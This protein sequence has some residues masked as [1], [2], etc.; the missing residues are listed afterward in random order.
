MVGFTYHLIKSYALGCRILW[1]LTSIFY[2][3]YLSKMMDTST[4]YSYFEELLQCE[5]E[6]V[7]ALKVLMDINWNQEGIIDFIDYY[8]FDVDYL[9]S[10]IAEWV[11]NHR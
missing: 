4:I 5:P 10:D 1:G 7:E 8:G 9:N 3:L 6:K 2:T 11:E